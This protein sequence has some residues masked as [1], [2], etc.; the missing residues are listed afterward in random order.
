[1]KIEE[2]SS[3]FFLKHAVVARQ[4]LAVF[5][6]RIIMKFHHIHNSKSDQYHNM[7]CSSPNYIFRKQAIQ[8]LLQNHESNL[9]IAKFYESLFTSAVVAAAEAPR[10]RKT[11]VR[12]TIPKKKVENE[13]KNPT[14]ILVSTYPSQSDSS[15]DAVK[16]SSRKQGL[17]NKPE[18]NKPKKEKKEKNKHLKESAGDENSKEKPEKSTPKS[19]RG[20]TFKQH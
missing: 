3:F 15:P 9:P 7:Y 2:N 16:T 20:L 1:V 13:N 10:A 11:I 18:K 4:S 12:P 8:A 5:V 17:K 6:R 19:F 14:P